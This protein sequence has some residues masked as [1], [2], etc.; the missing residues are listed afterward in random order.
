[1]KP[2]WKT[3]AFAG[4]VAIAC[5]TFGCVASTRPRIFVRVFGAGSVRRRERRATMATSAAGAIM[6]AATTAAIRSWR[7]G[8][9]RRSGRTRLRAPAGLSL[10]ARSSFPGPTSSPGRTQGIA[11]I[12]A[13][14]AAAGGELVVSMVRRPWPAWRS[15]TSTTDNGPLTNAPFYP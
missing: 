7:R 13:T 2:T 1:M 11:P 3:L 9:R 15:R 4:T 14:T 10:A 12:P 8:I 6:E 5:M